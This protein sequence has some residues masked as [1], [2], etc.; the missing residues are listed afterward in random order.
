MLTKISS[1]REVLTT[2]VRSEADLRT[3]NGRKMAFTAA[4][5]LNDFSLIESGDTHQ[6]QAN[7]LTCPAV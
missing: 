4:E 3:R 2:P 6:T 1:I 7:S 5:R